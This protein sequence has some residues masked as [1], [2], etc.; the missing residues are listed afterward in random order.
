MSTLGRRQLWR[1][2]KSDWVL[3][4]DLLGGC[5]QPAA[6][7]DKENRFFFEDFDELREAKYLLAAVPK[8]FGGLGLI[9]AEICRE[10]RR[11]ARHSAPTAL[12][13]N[14]HIGAT[15][16]AVDLRRKGDSSQVWLLEEAREGAVFSYGYSE[17]GN[18]FGVL[19]ATGKAERVDG[20]YDFFRHKHFGSLTPVW[21]W[22]NIYGL[23][24]A[25][26]D[27]AEIVHGVMARDLP[28]YRMVETWDTAC[29]R[30]PARTPSS[31]GLSFRISA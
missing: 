14:M 16:V 26:Q 8:E 22:L 23:H 25:N 20:G 13:I 11:L 21:T 17:S 10:Q 24:A 28:G 18:N 2:R 30:P 29:G 31:R 1:L 27:D 3:S 19:Y 4:E 9:L 7:Y 5:A 6:G 12:A 15:G